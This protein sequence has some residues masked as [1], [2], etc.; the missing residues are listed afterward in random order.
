MSQMGNENAALVIRLLLEDCEEALSAT[1]G[2]GKQVVGTETDQ[3]VALDL[4]LQEINL[5]Q[6]FAAD[7]RMARSVQQAIR[8]DGP[9]LS[10][11]QEEER[12]AENDH[13]LSIAVS[14][15]AT[16]STLEADLNAQRTIDDD[17]DEFIEKLLYIYVDGIEEIAADDD[18]EEGHDTDGD[19][20][21]ADLPE[22]SAWA[23]SRDKRKARPT[24][25]CVACGNHKHFADVA[26]APCGDE[27]CRE[28]LSRLFRDAM[29]DESLFPPRCCRLPIPLE[30][31][32]LFLSADL[33]RQF[34]KKAIEFSTPNR[35]YCHSSECA[36]F[37]PRENCS[38][39]TAVCDACG[40][41]TCTTCKSAEHGGD[42]PNDGPLQQVI[43]LA[44]EQNWQRCQ[45]CWG[46][47]ELNT[48]CNHITCRCGFQ[49]CYVCGAQWKTCHCDQ[50]DERRLY[51]RANEID[52]RDRGHDDIVPEGPVLPRQEADD[53]LPAPIEDDAQEHPAEPNAHEPA[54]L[55]TSQAPSV[56]GEVMTTYENFVPQ[57]NPS[58]NGNTARHRDRQQRLE[59][60]MQRL[61]YNHECSHDRWS[62]R[63]GPRRLQGYGLS[64]L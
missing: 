63:P 27:Y 18:P 23:A 42:C 6:E 38:E 43:E 54:I 30:R 49:F 40:L 55:D 34:R 4:H 9:A 32:R 52:A 51:E 20:D 22:S 64:P 1:V 35:T 60:L 47:V 61:R 41:R 7:R 39:N 28:C 45:N 31:N 62:N 21:V 17:D 15:G 26:R 12:R 19:S 11:S 58:N 14:Q 5:L 48:G 16:P 53:N 46:M 3:H 10:I 50:W 33:C 25:N 59:S 57:L 13:S 56:V 36:Q 2:K 8:S 44:R 37:I 29:I 24:R